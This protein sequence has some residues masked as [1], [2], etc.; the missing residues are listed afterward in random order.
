MV[1]VSGCDCEP[2]LFDFLVKVGAR[3][4]P[5]MGRWNGPFRGVYTLR[6]TGKMEER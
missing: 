3:E 2:V 1:Q 6:V 4:F 5:E